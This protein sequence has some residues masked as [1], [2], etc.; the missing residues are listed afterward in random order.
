MLAVAVEDLIQG[1]VELV[2]LV[3]EE[4]VLDLQE[5]LLLVEFLLLVEAVVDV[6]IR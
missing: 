1:Q 4:V 5:L 2:D 6:E 3:A